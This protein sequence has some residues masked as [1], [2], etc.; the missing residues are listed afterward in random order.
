MSQTA[1]TVLSDEILRL[2]DARTEA[3]RQAHSYEI[4]IRVLERMLQRMGHS[5]PADV[6]ASSRLSTG[7]LDD[8]QLCRCGCGGVPRTGRFLPGHD[9]R[10]HGRIK[11]HHERTLDRSGLTAE[12]LQA[13]EVA[14]SEGHMP[15]GAFSP[16]S[17]SMPTSV[18][19][20]VRWFIRHNRVFRPS[21]VVTFVKSHLP[22][23]KE[24]TTRT[25]FHFAVKD[26]LAERQPD[27]SYRS[28]VANESAEGG[29][30]D[31]LDD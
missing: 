31:D 7:S 4:E 22:S 23:A 21:D 19:G 25:Q 12:E 28:V 27:G 15:T 30:E 29:G 2:R 9:A 14:L 26:N 10:L 18:R 11:A 6:L 8:V 1:E 13:L 24:N 16:Q 5:E 3:L 20:L 17:A